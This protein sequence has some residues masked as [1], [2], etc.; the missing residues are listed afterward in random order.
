MRGERIPFV[1]KV[2]VM[3][4]EKIHVPAYTV[5]KI[6]YH[7]RFWML[8]P[9]IFLALGLSWAV[10][11]VLFVPE[12]WESISAALR[13]LAAPTVV[14]GGWLISTRTRKHLRTMDGVWSFDKQ[15]MSVYY[16]QWPLYD[17]FDRQRPVQLFCDIRYSDIQSISYNTFYHRIRI[18]GVMY[19]RITEYTPEGYLRPVPYLE[20]TKK[21]DF[22]AYLPEAWEEEIIEVVCRN[23]GWPME[24]VERTAALGDCFI[25]IE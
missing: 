10:S 11:G 14:C 2:F 4:Q 18:C 6:P 8:R 5:E 17:R 22:V 7:G 12:G 23:T 3:P 16:A 25:G 15:F 24:K 9:Y 19:R 20:G 21:G 1:R 13:L